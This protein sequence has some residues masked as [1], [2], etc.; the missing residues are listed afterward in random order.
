[1]NFFLFFTIGNNAVASKHITFPK[2]KLW[3]I[4]VAKALTFCGQ[5]T[6]KLHHVTENITCDVVLLVHCP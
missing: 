6:L 3:L 2:K 5:V 4:H 1:M